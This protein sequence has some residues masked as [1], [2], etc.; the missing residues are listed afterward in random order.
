[1]QV[2]PARALSLNQAL[3]M[4]LVAPLSGS[5]PLAGERL[6]AK[7]SRPAHAIGSQLNSSRTLRSLRMCADADCRCPDRLR[8]RLR[9]ASGVLCADAHQSASHVMNAFRRVQRYGTEAAR[10]RT[11]HR[12]IL[13]ALAH[14]LAVGRQH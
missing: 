5:S 3:F 4:L 13:E 1:M 7:G 2:L 11:T 6:T 10:L 9:L 14:L 8:V 12:V